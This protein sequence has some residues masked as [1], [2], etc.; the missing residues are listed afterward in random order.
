MLCI[1]QYSVFYNYETIK[2]TEIKRV[3]L[4][5]NENFCIYYLYSL[6]S[7][8][9]LESYSSIN[10]WCNDSPYF[11]NCIYMGKFDFILNFL[12]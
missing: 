12:C 8:D 5:E 7:N 10:R 3:F 11:R 4:K 6:I 1:N 2:I 9:T